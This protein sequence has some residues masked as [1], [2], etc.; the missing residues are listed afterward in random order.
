MISAGQLVDQ[1]ASTFREWHYLVGGACAGFVLGWVMHAAFA[2]H[3]LDASFR[4]D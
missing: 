3:A 2:L 4:D 1:F